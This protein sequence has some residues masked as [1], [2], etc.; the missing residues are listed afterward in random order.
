MQPYAEAVRGLPTGRL[1]EIDGQQISVE[2]AGQGPPLVLLHGFGESTLSFAAVLPELAKRFAVVAI[3]LN[4]FG[5]TE[6]PR[7]RESYTLAGQERLVLRVLDR[8][9]PRP[10]PPRR[11]LLRRGPG[12]LPRGAPSRAHR[13]AAAD[14][15]YAAALREPAPQS[16]LSPGGGSRGW[17]RTPFALSDRVITAG[18]EKGLL[19]R[20]QGHPGAGA[21]VRGPPADRRRHRRLLRTRRPLHRT[22]VPDRPGGDSDADTGGLGR[23][24]PADRGRGARRGALERAP[25]RE[26]RRPPRLRPHP[27]G[28]VPAGVPRRGAAV[29]ARGA[30]AAGQP[31]G[32]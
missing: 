17:R 26:L 27:D 5:Y 3:D 24:R 7:D 8:L 13:P 20:C 6:R 9:R 14:R 25:Q 31:G 1:L 32:P 29:P 16:A 11:T 2:R 15:Q 28:G 10:R 19:R 22:A 23:R 30:G 18:L 12:A 21:G 4:G